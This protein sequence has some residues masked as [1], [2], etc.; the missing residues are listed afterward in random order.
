MSKKK[1]E[2]EETLPENTLDENLVQLN[3]TSVLAAA[4]KNLG[5]L[6][7]PMKDVLED[8]SNYNLAVAFDDESGMLILELVE[9]SEA[10]VDES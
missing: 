1:K 10:A 6:A 3:L 8:Y 2:V 9:Q 5:V 4:V 7:V